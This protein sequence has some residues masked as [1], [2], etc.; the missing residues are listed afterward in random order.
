MENAEFLRLAQLLRAH[1]TKFMVVGGFAVNHYG[2]KR[3]TSDIDVYIEDSLENRR[4]LIES[5]DEMGYGRMETLIDVPIIA[6]YCEI[7]MDD[8]FYVDLMTSIPGLDPKD[9][10]AQYARR[11]VHLLDGV[12]IPYISYQD[13]LLNKEIT[14]R[15]KDLDDKRNLKKLHPMGE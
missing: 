3:T 7:M 12:E 5:L 1:G 2:Y 11:N 10:A 8:G 6:G 13:L 14:G 15:V 9:Y 4:A